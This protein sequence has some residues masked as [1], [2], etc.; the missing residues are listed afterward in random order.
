[1][2]GDLDTLLYYGNI[3]SR[4]AALEDK[5]SKLKSGTLQVAVLDH[6]TND[7][8]LQL[9][10][11]FRSGNGLEPGSGFSG[12]RMGYPGFDYGGNTWSLVGV[13]NDA[14]EF[15]ID[16]VTGKAVFGGG[17]GFLDANGISIVASSVVSEVRSYKITR[18][19]LTQ[20]FSMAGGIQNIGGTDHLIC[21]LTTVPNN[22]EQSEINIKSASWGQSADL[23]LLSEVYNVGYEGILIHADTTPANNFI[24]IGVTPAV[25]SLRMHGI[26]SL[27][28]GQ[29]ITEISTDGMMAANSDEKLSTQAAIVTYVAAHGGGIPDAP[30]NGTLY[31]RKNLG[32]SAVPA[33]GISDAPSDGSTYGRNNAAWVVVSAPAGGGCPARSFSGF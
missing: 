31:G 28:A 33:A 5:V 24:D 25:T 30:N 22:G 17:V 9:A 1:M 23:Y 32:W 29:T 21:Q 6:I 18:P 11:E 27:N 19:D 2:A 26:L 12:M 20:M 8:G 14:L 3:L 16:Y 15:G 13:N 10:G 4:V 7:I